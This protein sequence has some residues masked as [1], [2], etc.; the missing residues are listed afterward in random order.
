MSEERSSIKRLPIFE[1]QPCGSHQERNSIRAA[2]IFM[3]NTEMD[4]LR[5]PDCIL[6]SKVDAMGTV[7]VRKETG[8]IFLDFY[9]KGERDAENRTSWVDT[10]SN[11]KLA[12]KLLN[13]IE[14]REISQ[15]KF[16]Y[17]TYFPGSRH[18]ANDELKNGTASTIGEP[19]GFAH[20]VR[21]ESDIPLFRDF[22]NVWMNEKSPE[23]RASH[24]ATVAGTLKSRLLPIFG[25]QRLNCITKAQV[26]DFRATL[27]KTNAAGK[28]TTLSKSRINKILNPLRMILSEAADRFDFPSPFKGFKQLHIDRKRRPEAVLNLDFEVV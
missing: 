25:S 27:A 4:G 20:G 26:L 10:P 15:Q 23:W 2:C 5:G 14:A 9:F 8:V 22:A 16:D 6:E 24:E 19:A 28:S 11:R 17:Q 18:F 21:L 12:Q 3:N 13:K 1:M 7:R